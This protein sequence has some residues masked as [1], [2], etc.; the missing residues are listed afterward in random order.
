ML[1][2]IVCLKQQGD[3][4]KEDGQLGLASKDMQ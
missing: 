1:F 2:M 4:M 3:K